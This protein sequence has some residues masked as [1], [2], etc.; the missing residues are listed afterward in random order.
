MGRDQGLPRAGQTEFQNRSATAQSRA[1]QNT[2][3]VSMI[4]RLRK[5]TVQ[6]LGERGE[7]CER[8][9]PADTKDR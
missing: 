9:N 4:T 3:G 7:K 6:Q 2:A 8:S 1:C 5:N